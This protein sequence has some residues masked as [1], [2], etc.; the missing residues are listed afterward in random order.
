MNH[1]LVKPSRVLCSVIALT[2]SAAAAGAELDYGVLA[3]ASY[4]DNVLRRSIDEQSSGA[5]VVGFDLRGVRETGRLQYNLFADVEYRDYF[6]SGVEG[7]EFGRFIGL[8]SYSFVP[9]TFEWLLSASFDQVREDLLRPI[10]PENIENVT[11]ISTGPRWTLSFD[12][13]FEGSVEGHYTLASY[14]ESDSDSATAGGVLSFGRRLSERSYI[15]IGTSY[16]DV[17]YDVRP[18]VV[19]PDYERREY[20]LRFDTEGARTT[21]EADL[22]YAEVSG[23]GVDEDGPMVRARLTRRLTPYFSGFLGYTREFPTSSDSS[24][25]PEP[26]QGELVQDASILT[27]APRENEIAEIG[28]TMTRT[29]TNAMLVYARRS[30]STFGT[31]GEEREYDEVTAS[32]DRMITTRSSFGLYAIY[33]NEQLD[34]ITVD[35]LLPAVDD[36]A[37]ET[38][39][40]ANVLLVF[41]RA[42]G[43]EIRGEH[44]ER[45]TDSGTGE[46]KELSGGIF[47]RYGSARRQAQGLA[48]GPAAP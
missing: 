19:A 15:G 2:L 25:M 42:L 17:S 1:S 22:G 16:D 18:G 6:E 21:I 37:K 39:V 36:K 34:G 12:S 7:Q 46:Y 41:G 33:M 40:G 28:L 10:A 9:E 26:S 31:A 27:A 32:F 29:R 3:G 20:F 35:P 45:N 11:T 4:S 23:V 14:S 24:F 44:R 13:G 48:I 5:A 8:S 38:V 47:L 30:E 43:I